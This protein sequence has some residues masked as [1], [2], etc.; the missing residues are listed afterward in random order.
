MRI[1]L[2]LLCFLSFS[3]FSQ[4]KDEG[5]IS[6]QK[7]LNSSPKKV[8]NFAV[9]GNLSGLKLQETVHYKY[10]NA[11]WHFIRCTSSDL[12]SLMSDGIVEQIYFTPSAPRML[13]DS[14][15]LQQ[16]IDPIHAGLSPLHTPYKG[17]G[18]IMGY[19]DTGID[20]THEDFKNAD[21]STR[22]IRY[23]D[24]GLPVHPDRTPEKYG[25]GQIWTNTD[26]DNGNC[27]STDN[28]AHG[29]T[30]AGSGSGNGRA[31]NKFTGVAPE[32][33]I[34]MI[35]TNFSLENW[36]LT[37]ADAIDYL[38]VLADSLGKPAVMNTSVGDYLG[39]HDG[40]DP[41]SQIIDSLL[42]AKAG[43]IV[44]AAAGNSGNWDKYH[45][46]GDV[47]VDT[48][49]TWFEANTTSNPDTAFVVFDLWT[50]TADFNNVQFAF[51]AD[52]ELPN[53]E[54]R[55][56]TQFYSIA[57]L[58]NTTTEDSI[59]FNNTR[60]SPVRFFCEEV[61]GVY[62]IEV[63]IEPI[64]STDYL[65]RFM[66]TGN[67]SY[68]LWSGATIGLNKIREDNF[69]S[70]VDFPDILHIH[71]P[72]SLVSTVSSWACLESVITVGNVANQLD[73]IDQNGDVYTFNHTPGKLSINSSK[74]PNRK[75]YV[76]PDISAT[77]DGTLSACPEYLINNLINNGGNAL[78]AGL[79]HVRNGGTSMAC[80]VIA[81]IA[82]L[83]LEKCNQSTY[84]DFKAD[85]L[86][87]AHEDSYTGTTP[88]FA[89]GYGKIDA[90][91]LLN[92]TNYSIDLLGDSLICDDTAYFSIPQTV[93]NYF[94][95]TGEINVSSISVLGDDIISAFTVNNKGCIAYTDT[96]EVIDG[97]M[98][99]EPYIDIIGG[100][101]VT[102]P[103]YEHQWYLN[104]EPI[105]DGNEQFFNPEISGL[106]EVI[107]TSIDGCSLT[108]E[109]RDIDISTI[110]E[111]KKNEFVVFP[112]PFTDGFKIIKNDFYDVE[113][114]ITDARGR[115]IY[116]LEQI[117]S[118]NL[119][120]SVN[121]PDLP[122]GV[123]FMQLNYNNSYK[124][125]KLVRQ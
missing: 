38:F 112:N 58:L 101:L 66:T 116:N 17:K 60:I 83:Y 5:S 70:A 53:F 84:A 1:L 118:S 41:A 52:Q 98:P 121:L 82:A 10:S 69:P 39:S 91:E 54:F 100:G 113:L 50:D 97:I 109:A 44:V 78:D 45:V 105:D 42:N 34:V 47:D 55:G 26:I 2:F 102:T 85:L 16:N 94:W 32:C 99:I 20:F 110:N 7:H 114:N 117:D 19:I 35:E 106:Y 23:W 115:L 122:S 51:G 31:I 88:N 49:F 67:G 46:H 24:Q 108:S 68:D 21:G 11:D 36:T 8:T 15:R 33:D 86:S 43:R 107:V 62:H 37:V 30:V 27:T 61:N 18:V 90:F 72:D 71:L 120:I 96:I 92:K 80:P 104:G 57:G 29:S 56:R 13:N 125:I 63:Y 3:S 124:T 9:K 87:T 59:M 95:S 64:D 79:K 12:A 25:Y 40:T 14:M 22:V 73:Y 4:Q 89:Y 81:G 74:G 28:H 111:L 123:Y 119:F 103:A 6:F 76:K 75:N 48:S 65:F 77:G 93:S